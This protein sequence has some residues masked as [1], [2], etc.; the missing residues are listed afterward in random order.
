ME[1]PSKEVERH[2]HEVLDRLTRELALVFFRL[3]NAARELLG[4]GEHSSGRRSVLKSLGEDGAQTVPEMARE[5]AVSRQHVQT[6]VDGLKASGL[7]EQVHNPLHKRSKLVRLTPRGRRFLKEMSLREERLMV[8]LSE[9]ILTE[10][11]EVAL[12]T[13][14]RLRRKLDG[15]AWRS[16]LDEAR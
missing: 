7:V 15:E 16:L 6:L 13:V 11:M 5:R 9:G 2:R 12:Q 3:R 1:D 14:S 10:E 4:E 8:F